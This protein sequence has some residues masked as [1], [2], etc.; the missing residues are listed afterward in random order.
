MRPAPLYHSECS[1]A[2]LAD[3]F[4]VCAQR[5][6]VGTPTL[7]AKTQR[8]AVLHHQPQE[9]SF[10]MKNLEHPEPHECVE[11][12]LC[13]DEPQSQKFPM[14]TIESFA[15][16]SIRPIEVCRMNLPPTFHTAHSRCLMAKFYSPLANFDA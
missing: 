16:Q 14:D 6:A 13:G 3:G 1:P 4:Y 2:A 15:T 8:W 5:S 7:T 12:M 10:A 11:E 9:E